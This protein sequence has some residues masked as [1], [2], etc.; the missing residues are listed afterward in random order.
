MFNE[1]GSGNSTLFIKRSLQYYNSAASL[2]S[3]DPNPRIE[4]SSLCDKVIRLPL[5]KADL[6]VFD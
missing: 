4:I 2:I 1:I 5:E 6:S 3:I